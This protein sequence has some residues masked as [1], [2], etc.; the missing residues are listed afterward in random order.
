MLCREELSVNYF[1]FRLH[2]SRSFE[3]DPNF[4]RRFSRSENENSWKLAASFTFS[5]SK[6]DKREVE[7]GSAHVDTRI[8]EFEWQF[9]F[10]YVQISCIVSFLF[11]DMRQI[12]YK[13]TTFCFFY[14]PLSVV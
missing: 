10:V 6:R 2:F 8:L 4:A 3:G 12:S 5:F 9:S 14:S 1:S 13:M 7:L 11:L